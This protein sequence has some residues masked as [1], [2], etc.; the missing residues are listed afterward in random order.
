MAL[1]VV[2]GLAGCNDADAFTCVEDAQC[3]QNGVDGTCQPL[4][5]CSFDDAS[6]ASGQR[7][8]SLAPDGVA[9]K[10]VPP[11]NG[12]DTDGETGGEPVEPGECGNAIAEADEPCDGSD[13]GGRTCA[14]EG[15]AGGALQCND[16]CTLDT[17]F[18]TQCGNGVVDAGEEC[19]GAALSDAQTCADVG[20]GEP[21]EALGCSDA[22]TYDYAECSACGD[23]MVTAP[24]ACD[25]LAELTETCES[26][27]FDGGTL[28]CTKGC[29]L[30]ASG[31]ALCGNGMRDGAEVCDGAD[32][33][34]S[35]CDS[36]GFQGGALQCGDDC[37]FDV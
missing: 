34:T 18:C 9:G 27:G 35:T 1:M 4:G 22:C 8:G 31:C 37:T 11:T 6:C 29:G 21:T 17:A 7:Y 5:F 26:A 16:D 3:Q 19:D 33:G 10:C 30:D 32:L 12:D 28:A 13:L 36:E 25:P 24:E 2:A 15:F 23:G 14:S 20:L